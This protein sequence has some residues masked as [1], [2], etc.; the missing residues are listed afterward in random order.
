MSVAVR[1]AYPL[2]LAR[3]RVAH[4]PAR[5]LL[6]AAGIAAGACVLAL[7]DAGSLQIRDRALQRAVAELTPS[8]RAV[9]V[10]WFGTISTGASSFSSLD[11][12]VRPQLRALEGREPVAAMLYREASI[13]GP[14]V[15]LRGVDGVGRWVKLVSGR[16]PKPCRP[17][18]CEVLRIQG[19]GPIP[20]TKD[21]QLVEVGRATLPADAPFRD[22]LGRPPADTSVL[23]RAIEYHT[24]PNPPLVLAEG[25]RGLAS[26][27][28]L[29]TF[30]RS[31][32]WFAP[33]SPGDVHPWS[34]DAFRAKVDRLRSEIGTQSL[35]QTQFDLTAPTDELAAASEQGKA[36]AR[37]FLLLGGQAAALLLA[38][39]LLSA[40][41]LRRESE[42][43][44]RRLQ[45]FG[46]RRWQVTL[47]GLG[48]TGAVAAVATV[49]GW[50][51]GIG[52][53]AAVTGGDVVRHSVAST[54]GIAVAAGLA[55]AAAL[56]LLA[57][58]RAPAARLGGASVS[59]VDM[60]ALGALL[61][62]GIGLARGDA[63]ASTLASGSG[64]GAFLLLLPA[65][66]TFVAAVVCARLLAPLLRLL[67]RVGR[68]GP[69]AARLAA[70]SLARRPGH[71]TM[72][73]A[74]LAV[75]LGLALFAVAYRSTLAAGQRDQAAYA[76]PADYVVSE[77][78]AQL[79]PV[80]HVPAP[81][82]AR[83]VLRQTGDVSR[84]ETTNGADVLGLT[85]AAAIDGWRP[86]FASPSLA[87]LAAAIHPAQPV[88]L[89]TQPLV[90]PR[91][92]LSVTSRGYPIALRADVRLANG[93]WAS[94]KVG[95]T[96]FHGSRSYSV[97]L[98][99][100]SRALLGFT[101]LL[102]NSG[103]STANAGTG[104]QPTANGTLRI[105]LAGADWS[106]WTPVG[107]V[108]ADGDTLRY[109]LTTDTPSGF[110]L[111]QAT[112]GAAIPAIVSP[113]LAKAAGADRRLPF[114]ISGE[115]VTLEVA[116]VAKRFPGTTQPDFVVADFGT[117]S[118]ALDALLPG[119][120]G[121]TELW[122]DG[123]R[124]HEPL[125]TVQSQADLAAQLRGDPLA[126]GALVV[127]GGT[128][129]VALALALV[130]L[131]LGLVGDL[132]DEG[133]ELFDLESQGAEPRLLRR[134]LR[135]RTIVVAAVGIAGGIATGA[136][137]AALVLSLVRATA[138]LAAP[139]PPLALTLDW[140]LVGIGAAVLLAVG[141]AAVVAASRF[142]FHARAAGRFRE[143]A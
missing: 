113:A 49:V 71:A 136:V 139:Q 143:L 40:S 13:G 129:L 123:P 90:G 114:E 133:G 20:T 69:L 15:D 56:L 70:L 29:A 92:D 128:A 135:L 122:V 64:T 109:G 104:I 22:F 58:L 130:G 48:E 95:D 96:P 42:A 141:A 100:G 108:V 24:P 50:A 117:L 137:L 41:T 28:E 131:V 5:L 57:A 132:R 3:A 80:N 79:V 45:W 9:Q 116:G 33:L 119:L 30:Y 126:H 65:L 107:N 125:L 39:V 110:R 11:R 60:A 67:E 76:V 93:D 10:T 27:P 88:A 94:V 47:F 46:A 111:A 85:D 51:L 91:L 19:T 66:V 74:F 140:S 2:R 36:S 17:S 97:R 7:V 52:I 6:V 1:F 26:T 35:D 103:R 84:L 82:G 32:A 25:V 73:V 142:A 99:E 75:S 105:R 81:S 59:V 115:R 138:N 38:F 124:P 54:G 77:D 12:V 4:R 23:S 8:Q 21:L 63:D 106:R 83:P 78:L 31:Y 127:L 87:R 120:G 62:I 53:A 68:R 16:L 34:V 101:F 72:A 134:H 61:A 98:P 102:A 55:V 43:A 44:R 14:L 118:T 37:R 121:E 18:H 86:D 89:R 112:D